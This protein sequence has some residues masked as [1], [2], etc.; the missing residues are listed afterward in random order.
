MFFEGLDR[1][2]LLR[3]FRTDSL[4]D[5]IRDAL[6]RAE[7]DFAQ[8]A[9]INPERIARTIVSDVNAYQADEW[10]RQLRAVGIDFYSDPDIRD[11]IEVSIAENVRLITDLPSKA[12]R[13]IEGLILRAAQTGARA[14]EI[15]PEIAKIEQVTRTRAI[16]IARDQA[17]K[18]YGALTKARQ[19][20]LGVTHYYWRSSR[21]EKVRPRHRELN[22]RRIAWD[23]PPEEG[24]PGHPIRCRC[25]AEADLSTVL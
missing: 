2:A 11:L 1:G 4:V 12:L 5:R 8:R 13:D 9:G 21:D 7:V 17:N 24:H 25:T 18:L 15:A 6:R 14:E 22:G 16:L 10:A 23:N 20:H 3:E 19:V